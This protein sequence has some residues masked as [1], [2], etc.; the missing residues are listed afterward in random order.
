MIDNSYLKKCSRC[1]MDKLASTS[2]YRNAA[3]KD[4]FANQCKGCMKESYRCGAMAR[5]RR[6]Y[7]DSGK[8]AKACSKWGKTKKGRVY[9]DNRKISVNHSRAHD[10][11]R[12]AVKRGDL[13]RPDACSKCD[14]KGRVQAHHDDYKKPLVVIWVCQSCHRVLDRRA[15]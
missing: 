3:Q 7:I 4:G 11:V 5:W 15:A 6:E 9:S 10:A 1:R 8:S 13:V 14:R 12:R 2:F